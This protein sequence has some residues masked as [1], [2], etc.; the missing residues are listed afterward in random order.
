MVFQ[1]VDCK[2]FLS[3]DEDLDVECRRE[4]C[5]LR[6]VQDRE[7][8]KDRKEASGPQHNKGGAHGWH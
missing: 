1:C 5:D 8:E 6:E 7:Y 2:K 4:Q 3:G